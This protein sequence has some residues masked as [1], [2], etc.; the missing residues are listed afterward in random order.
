MM[1]VATRWSIFSLRGAFFTC[2][3]SILPLSKA[4]SSC[5]KTFNLFK[6][7]N[8]KAKKQHDVTRYSS[9][10]F[11]CIRNNRIH[12]TF[13]VFFQ[14]LNVFC[15]TKQGETTTVM[16]TQIKISYMDHIHL[17]CKF[18]GRYS[19][20]TTISEISSSTGGAVLL[21]QVDS[22][23]KRR[24]G[25]RGRN[26]CLPLEGGRRRMS[27]WFRHIICPLKLYFPY[28]ELKYY[29]TFKYRILIESH[30][31]FQHGNMKVCAASTAKLL[32][33]VVGSRLF[34]SL[35]LKGR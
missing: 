18:L 33:L 32:V 6:H 27:T 1:F 30:P 35:S 31:T 25:P 8:L 7:L 11:G 20:T 23:M 13:Q 16:H 9:V 21:P 26:T 34:T 19:L 4:V 15:P 17:S 28:H 14:W 3:F 22:W 10:T 5:P 29:S 2:L 24:Y 12:L